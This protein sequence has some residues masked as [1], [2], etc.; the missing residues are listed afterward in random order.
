[1]SERLMSTI[2]RGDAAGQHWDVIVVGA[3]IAGSLASLGLARMGRKV[4][5]IERSTLPR[6]KVCGACLNE[7]AIGGLRNAGV[8]PAIE[9]LGG[10]TLGQFNIRAG[11]SRANLTL[12]GGH[13]VSRFAMDR[14]LAESAIEAGT[15]IL[16]DTHITTE[17]AELESETRSVL[18]NEGNRYHASVVVVANGLAGQRVSDDPNDRVVIESDSRIGLGA[19]WQQSEDGAIMRLSGGVVYMA[20]GQ[21]GY[22]GMVGT[23]GGTVNLAAAVDRSAVQSSGPAEVCNE[24]LHSVG[25]DLGSELMNAGFRGTRTMTRRRAVAGGHRLFFAGDASGY[26]E[27]FTGEGMAWAVRAGMAVVPWADEAVA[28][29]QTDIPMRW[30]SDLRRLLG[31]QQRRCRLLAKA[32]RHPTLVR[33]TVTT[34]SR[35]PKLGRFAVEQIHRERSLAVP[36]RRPGH[37]RAWANSDAA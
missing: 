24:V 33:H 37:R 25:W 28:A 36:D 8:W 5:L 4:L 21:S 10:F 15:Q 18:D 31:R 16:C 19:H 9:A 26:V 13:A 12:P 3:G 1:M 14:V 30:T 20:V 23:E 22:V 7:D 11:T 35:F 2:T 29:W 32:L 6:E 34:L 27:P 17:D